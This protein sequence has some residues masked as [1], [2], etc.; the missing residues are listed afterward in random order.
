MTIPLLRDLGKIPPWGASARNGVILL[1]TFAMSS[2]LEALLFRAPLHA[3]VGRAAVQPAL[4][5]SE[6]R[7]VMLERL[8][9]GL[10]FGLGL[11]G[12]F[13]LLVLLA[14]KPTGRDPLWGLLV[15]YAAASVAWA[16]VQGTRK[17]MI[18][19]TSDLL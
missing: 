17:W 4:S 12:V 5:K 7:R 16:I 11:F 2:G 19:R 10:L 8:P 1:L 18:A 14:L 3:L 13:M 15:V 6:R 9:G